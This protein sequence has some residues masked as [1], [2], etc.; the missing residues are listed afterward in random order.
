MR[1]ML[2]I[3]LASDSSAVQR[4][5]N[6]NFFDVPRRFQSILNN[7]SQDRKAATDAAAKARER[8]SSGAF[9]PVADGPNPFSLENVPS[10]T[11]DSWDS[12]ADGLAA[13][14]KKLAAGS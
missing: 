7:W 9:S 2:D 12:T 1:A 6:G 8:S 5:S 14:F 10:S 11:F 4:V 3:D 13:A